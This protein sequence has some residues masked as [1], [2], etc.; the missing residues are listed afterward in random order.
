MNVSANQGMTRKSKNSPKARKPTQKPDNATI[1][2]KPPVSV[3]DDLQVRIAARAYELYEGRG[4][5]DGYA[6]E[7]WVQAE[8]EVLSQVPPF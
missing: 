3:C 6:I 4:R 1:R 8:R 7:D 2:S 5:R